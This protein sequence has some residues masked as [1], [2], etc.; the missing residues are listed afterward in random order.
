[1]PVIERVVGKKEKKGKRTS[2]KTAAH[3]K[4]IIK[5]ILGENKTDA[6][7]I[8]SVNLID[9]NN[10]FNEFVLT[11]MTFNKMPKSKQDTSKRMVV[12][13]V[14][15]FD[16]KDKNIT[17]ELAK[18]IADEFASSIYFKEFQMVYAVHMDKDHIH[19]HFV[20]NTTNIADG[21]A[22]QQTAEEL[23]AMKQL[24]DKIALSHGVNIINDRS[25][26]KGK[27]KENAEYQAEKRG[28]SWK[29]EIFHLCKEAKESSSSI[30]EY[31]SKLN[32]KGV[33]VKL[34]ETRKDITYILN[35]K[36]INSDKLGFHKRGF[37][38][39]TKEALAKYFTKKM[40]ARKIS[41]DREKT[42][43]DTEN[44]E[45]NEN[46]ENISYLYALGDIERLLTGG[47]VKNGNS[48]TGHSDSDMARRF[49]KEESK[50][51]RGMEI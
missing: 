35:G 40:S 20:I 30:E 29:K 9:K 44:R 8:G 14:Q 7:L 4:N 31:I 3:M 32:E 50:K 41:E 23:E 21:K 11:K 37:T 15:S 45:N 28:V 48:I 16:P 39:F 17:P 47:D 10:A 25:K 24:S 49:N 36:K 26:D 18:K 12:H 6:N 19:T 13:F 38:P 33:T 42:K 43:S 1:M 22:W 34:S 2:Y 5:Y 46:N 27:H 51:S